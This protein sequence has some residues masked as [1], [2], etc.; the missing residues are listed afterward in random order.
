MPSAAPEPTTQYLHCPSRRMK[1]CCSCS[2]ENTLSVVLRSPW[3]ASELSH[4]LLSL[5][6]RQPLTCTSKAA[7]KGMERDRQNDPRP[8]TAKNRDPAAGEKTI[9]GLPLL[10][11]EGAGY[12]TPSCTYDTDRLSVLPD[13]PDVLPLPGWRMFCRW[14]LGHPMADSTG[15][16][17]RC[18]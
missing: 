15:S 12:D 9:R 5:P 2:A 3:D 1:S 6:S 10:L 14:R 8:V 13:F 17:A 7:P 11:L 16:P 18:T 4:S